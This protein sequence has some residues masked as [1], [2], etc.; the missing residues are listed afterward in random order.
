MKEV[1]VV[2]NRTVGGA[3]LPLAML[4]AFV[5]GVAMLVGAAGRLPSDVADTEPALAPGS[6]A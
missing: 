1:L 4:W 5:I 3:K 6:S 2:A